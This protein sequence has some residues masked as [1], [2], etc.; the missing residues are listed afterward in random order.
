MHFVVAICQC[1][2]K[3]VPGVKS[4]YLLTFNRMRGCFIQRNKKGYDR[5][6]RTFCSGGRIRSQI[7]TRMRRNFFY[8]RIVKFWISL[9]QRAINADS[10]S[11]LMVELD[12]LLN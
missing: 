2:R 3:L 6:L 1:W 4:Q 11:L 12:K 5:E 10:L 7:K 8:Q 9:L